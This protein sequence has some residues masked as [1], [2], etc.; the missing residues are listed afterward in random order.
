MKE[1][2]KVKFKPNTHTGAFKFDGSIYTYGTIRI[3]L[4]QYAKVEAVPS[5]GKKAK[6]IDM[7]IDQLREI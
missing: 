7:R 4:G 1:G 2:Q 6:M 5:W 3:I